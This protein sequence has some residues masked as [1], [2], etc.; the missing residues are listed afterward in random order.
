MR[1]DFSPAELSG[2]SLAGAIAVTM[3]HRY[4]CMGT[5]CLAAEFAG[6]RSQVLAWQSF[7]RRQRARMHRARAETR[8]FTSVHHMS[9]L[10]LQP[11]PSARPPIVVVGI[12]QEWAARSLETVL[13][14][15]GFAV[16]RAY[17]GRQT[18][19]FAEVA[20]PDA[21]L[22][23]SRLPDMDGVD[24]CRV[25]RDEQRVG[26]QVPIIVTTSGPAPRE[27]LRAAYEAGAWSVWEQ[28]LD[29]ELMLLRL[30][31]WVDAKRVLDD[32]ERSSLVDME[33]GLYSFLGLTRRAREVM[34][35]AA[36]SSAPVACIALAP[37]ASRAASLADELP[38]P[39]RVATDVG[40]LLAGE[41]RASDVIGRM[42][43]SEFA[44]LAPMTERAGAL[45]L[46]ER[47]RDRVASMPVQSDDGRY[48]RIMLRAGLAT[49]TPQALEQRD[50]ANLLG[51]AAA[52]LRFA[53][54]SRA[55]NV[56]SYDEV[57]PTFV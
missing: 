19:D 34:A 28:P 33:S 11:D 53:Q 4:C 50:G 10:P 36:R 6:L 22:I 30:Q 2:D 3:M 13:G 38:V 12:E 55:A 15:R 17:S 41:A 45:E 39:A 52:A 48:S 27:F 46:V 23:D 47:L 56:R 37:M 1:I 49:L 18:L 16:V 54:S 26:R 20:A 35:E 42:G 7:A 8:S 25:L 32:T 14:P 44:I 29:G 31:T 9:R 51:R 43:A 24:V 57:P 5:A 21:V 40:R